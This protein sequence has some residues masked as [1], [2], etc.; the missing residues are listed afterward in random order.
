MDDLK[1]KDSK[2]GVFSDFERNAVGST[3]C[4]CIK[5]GLFHSLFSCR[6]FKFQFN[7]HLACGL[8]RQFVK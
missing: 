7:E 3:Y 5:I 8:E 4:F 2:S 6:C 1:L